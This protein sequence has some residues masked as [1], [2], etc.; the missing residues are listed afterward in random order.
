MKEIKVEYDETVRDANY[1]IVQFL[2]G[3]DGLDVSK[4]DGGKIG[5]IKTMRD[6]VGE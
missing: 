1:N 3:E 4:T 6:V 2:Y 5:V